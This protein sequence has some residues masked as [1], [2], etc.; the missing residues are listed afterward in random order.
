MKT[1]LADAAAIDP[2]AILLFD[3]KEALRDAIQGIGTPASWIRSKEEVA[4]ALAAKA[5]QVQQQNMLAQMETASKVAG[6][7]ADAQQSQAGAVS[8]MPRPTN[9][10]QAAA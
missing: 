3:V 8:Q 6:N 10:V 9:M 1:L 2:D 7:L 4:Q 5:K